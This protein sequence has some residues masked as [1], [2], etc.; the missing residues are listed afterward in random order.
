MTRPEFAK[1][2]ARW[3]R[4]HA[5]DPSP[6]GWTKEYADGWKAAMNDMASMFYDIAE[7]LTPDDY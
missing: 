4:E 6:A 5:D 3:C 7:I 2:V 1:E